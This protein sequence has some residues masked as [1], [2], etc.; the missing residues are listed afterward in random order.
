MKRPV[1]QDLSKSRTSDNGP[2]YAF[3]GEQLPRTIS[4]T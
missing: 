4:E 1:P 2:V 3:T